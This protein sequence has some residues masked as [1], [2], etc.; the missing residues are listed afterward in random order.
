MSDGMQVTKLLECVEEI[1]GYEQTV[2]NIIE[3]ALQG[4][5]DEVDNYVDYVKKVFSNKQDDISDEEL[6]SIVL[7]L[8]IFLFHLNTVLQ[9]C[10]LKKGLAEESQNQKRALATLNAVGTV[11]ERSAKADQQCA[12]ATIVARTYKNICS[13]L[14]G[15]IASVTEILASAKKV[16]SR[17]ITE[18]QIQQQTKN[19][20]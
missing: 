9:R 8:P 7:N 2:Q 15:K 18:M 1:K 13:L 14:Q 19:S 20:F 3:E 17:R 10:D 11:Q 12:E 6:N 4:S 5:T 16:Q